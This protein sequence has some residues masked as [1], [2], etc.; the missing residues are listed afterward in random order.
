MPEFIRT[1]SDNPDFQNLTSEL[2]DELCRIYNTNKE[3]YEEYNRIT[4]L[5]T[6]VLA[7]ENDIAIACGCFK[8]F[9]AHRLELKRMFVT[10]GFRGKGIASMMVDELE[11]W[12][13]ELGYGTM[14]L[15]TGKGQPDAIALYRKLGYTD[16]PHFGE[17]PEESRSVC[18]GKKIQQD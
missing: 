1:T 3:D 5:P 14:I 10:P 15:E 18:L 13:K 7:Y 4:G 17:F 16:I 12:G 8:Q 2:D 9:D 11:K 6:V